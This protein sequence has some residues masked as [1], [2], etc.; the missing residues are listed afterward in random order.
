MPGESEDKQTQTSERESTT[1]RNPYAPS[2]PLLRDIL[3]QAQGMLGQTGLTGQESGAISGL[4]GTGQAAAGFTPQ[5]QGLLGNMI[6]GQDPAGQAASTVS[7]ALTPVV[8]GDR[9][10]LSGNPYVQDIVGQAQDAARNQVTSRFAAGGRS[11]S[12]SESQALG[13]GITD[14]TTS[15]LFDQYNTEAGRQM[16]AAG[17][18]NQTGQGALQ[19]RLQGV[20]LLPQLTSLEQQ[21]FRSQLEAAS[22]ERGIPQQQLGLLSDLVVPVASG[23]GATEE[24]GT[25]TSTTTQTQSSNPVQTAVGAGIAGLGLL[26]GNPMMAM[27]GAQAGTGGLRAGGTTWS[28][29]GGGGGG[30]LPWL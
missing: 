18:L 22:L 21:P 30:Q 13:Q 5:V 1:R 17:L 15:A 12:P 14:A 27:Q 29:G 3:G 4:A 20:G 23:F 10:D 2:E 9:L 24:T 16:Q 7:G 28:P 8:Q 6:S 26:S 25:G 11:F 19:S